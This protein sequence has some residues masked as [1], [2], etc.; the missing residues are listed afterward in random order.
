MLIHGRVQ[1]VFFRNSIRERARAAGV[2]GRARNREDG[3]VEV[4][5]E[6]AP[7]AVERLLTFCREGPDRARVEDVTVSDEEPEGLDSFDVD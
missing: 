6:G 5:L 4:I 7:A 2:S 3:A 1:G